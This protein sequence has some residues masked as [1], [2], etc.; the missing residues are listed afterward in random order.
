MWKRSIQIQW[1][2]EYFLFRTVESIAHCIPP[3]W[4]YQ[5][6]AVSG[7]LAYRFAAKR[8]DAAVRNL[9]AAFGDEKSREEIVTLSREVF[10]RNIANVAASTKTAT[11]PRDK[12]RKHLNIEGLD[13][14]QP[15]TDSGMGIIAVLAHMG[16]WEILAQVG[17]FA[18]PENHSGALYR[19]LNNPYLDAL[20]KKRRESQK[21]VTFSR[22]DKLIAPTKHLKERRLRSVEVFNVFLIRNLPGL[23]YRV[24]LIVH[25]IWIE[26][27]EE[28]IPASSN[29]TI[30]VELRLGG[31]TLGSLFA[32]RRIEKRRYEVLFLANV[33]N[34]K[35]LP[36]HYIQ[37]KGM[38]APTVLLAHKV[39][40]DKFVK[41]LKDDTTVVIVNRSVSRPFET[42]LSSPSQ[43]S[44]TKF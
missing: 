9:Q 20:I 17:Q 41:F 8:R 22:R 16:N 11:M 33:S 35:L 6:G 7:D 1:K 25:P 43:T 26:L 34:G 36:Y 19:P 39:S 40:V 21:N 30:E 12:I 24:S 38:A 32:L 5:L 37:R 31:K 10:R 13:E 18:S 29:L 15:L 3:S 27:L 2:A 44:T 28:E 14:L 23:G 42:P 4:C